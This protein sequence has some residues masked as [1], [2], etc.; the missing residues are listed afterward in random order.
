MMR[1]RKIH[2]RL[3]NITA[4]FLVFTAQT[5]ENTIEVRIADETVWLSQKMIG[6]LFSVEPHT[7]NYHLQEIYKTQELSEESTTRNFRVVQIEGQRKVERSIKFYNLDVIGTM[8][9]KSTS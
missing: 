5:N 1:K 7:I 6:E 8:S 9:R 3:R 4:E 2:C